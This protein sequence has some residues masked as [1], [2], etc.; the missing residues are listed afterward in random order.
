MNSK[1]Y[2]TL[3]LLIQGPI[4]FFL[5][6]T[7]SFLQPKWEASSLLQVNL[8]NHELYI[9]HNPITQDIHN[10][11]I[12]PTRVL[13]LFWLC[14]LLMF[15]I[16]EMSDWWKTLHDI[17][18][19]VFNKIIDSSKDFVHVVTSDW[20]KISSVYNV[21]FAIVLINLINQFRQFLF[22]NR[23]FY[24]SLWNCTTLYECLFIFMHKWLYCF[25][26]MFIL[27]LNILMHKWTG[28]KSTKEARKWNIEL[29]IWHH[30]L[31]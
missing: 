12:P 30:Q 31:C 11:F 24:V 25:A 4:H 19:F 10:T 22:F 3:I 18:W 23:K 7:S 27:N 20:F 26:R 2:I 13:I 21:N 28:S 17:L 15:I 5:S 9:A 29:P 14:F 1:L 16:W 8:Q 6:L